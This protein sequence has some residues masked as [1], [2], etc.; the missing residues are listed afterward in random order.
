VTDGDRRFGFRFAPAYRRAA[1]PFGVTPE[2]AEVRVGGGEL[3][4]RYGPWRIRTPLSNIKRVAITGPYRFYRTAG[5]ARLGVT[6]WGLTFA[7]NGERG[8]CVEFHEPIK[9]FEPIG[10]RRHPNLTLTVADV[11]GL[12]AALHAEVA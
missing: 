9:G 2:R 5:P 10:L 12:A 3:R 6:D 11:E 4:A 7:S 8:V 1:L